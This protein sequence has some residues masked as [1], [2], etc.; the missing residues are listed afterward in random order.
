MEAAFHSYLGPMPADADA[1]QLAACCCPMMPS[2]TFF[3]RLC[4]MQ[5]PP[6]TVSSLSDLC[7]CQ[8][9]MLRL[10]ACHFLRLRQEALEL[11]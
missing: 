4:M 8:A 2:R 7:T 10:L 6:P 9:L 3:T 1:G 11:T 5:A